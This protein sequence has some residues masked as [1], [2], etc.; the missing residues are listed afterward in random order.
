MQASIAQIRSTSPNFSSY[1]AP[2]TEHCVINS[3]ALY[4][5]TVG[6]ARL[7]D[8]IRTLADARSPASVP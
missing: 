8:W 2:G 6:S 5:T 7:V 3:P 4:T 1:I